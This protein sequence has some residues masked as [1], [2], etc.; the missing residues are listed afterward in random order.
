M[1]VREDLIAAMQAYADA[2]GDLDFRVAW[3]EPGY[4]VEVRNETQDTGQGWAND[5]NFVEAL[6]AS[7]ATVLGRQ[8]EDFDLT[9][10]P[11]VTLSGTPSS[12]GLLLVFHNG[13]L[14]RRKASP[15]SATEYS[16][17]E[18]TKLITFGDSVSGWINVRY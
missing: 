6:F 10:A 8:S 4:R 7:I 3:G 13:I 18:G 9:L 5:P 12:A 16:W 17:V 11:S 14:L 15:S 2:S 1:A